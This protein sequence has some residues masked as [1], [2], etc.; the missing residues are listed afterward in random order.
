MSPD[1]RGQEFQKAFYGR[2][3]KDP[4][5]IEIPAPRRLWERGPLVIAVVLG[6][7]LAVALMMGGCV[8]LPYHRLVVAEERLKASVQM[9]ERGE[10]C[11]E[12]V[13]R[14]RGEGIWLDE[15]K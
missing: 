14:A 2:R 9:W 3:K 8:S 15:S 12:R 7:M 1:R 10:K 6:V 11:E 4:K 5:P 13:R